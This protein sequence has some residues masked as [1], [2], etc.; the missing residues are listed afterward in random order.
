MLSL[1]NKALLDVSAVAVGVA[2]IGVIA[3]AGTDTTLMLTGLAIAGFSAVLYGGLPSTSR[4]EQILVKT[5]VSHLILGVA[6]AA[7]L[8]N[9]QEP[10]SFSVK[11]LW[12]MFGL[13]FLSTLLKSFVTDALQ[14]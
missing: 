1:R 5:P 2:G 8:W 10:G 6:V 14:N 3:F 12:W 4:F 11:L 9:L 7:V 13:F